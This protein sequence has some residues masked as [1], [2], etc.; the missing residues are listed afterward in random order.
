MGGTIACALAGVFPERVQ[1]AVLLEGY[2][3]LFKEPSGAAALLREAIASR[4]NL[5]TKMPR[6][7]ASV[8]DAVKA[9]MET[10]T[11]WP[12]KQS[13][14]VDAARA[15]VARGTA[16][17]GAGVVFRH[18][19]QLLA[20]EFVFPTAA[21]VESYIHGIAC[22]VLIVLARSGGWPYDAATV[23]G[24]AA[25]VAWPHG[26]ATAA[27]R[28]QRAMLGHFKRAEL[29]EVDDASH[30]LHID[31][32]SAHRVADLVVPFLRAGE[33]VPLAGDTK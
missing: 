28:V 27:A 14:S 15:L 12:G 6:V 9:R 23:S 25:V 24:A 33:D 4:K 19:L 18:D 3:P 30:H 7:F 5:A 21:A 17:T 16:R 20:R 22:D 2:S 31:A 26:R 1:R 10:A 29:H 8:E 11:R 32:R 13:L